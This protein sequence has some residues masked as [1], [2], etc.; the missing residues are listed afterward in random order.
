[1]FSRYRLLL[2]V[3]VVV[4]LAQSGAA[5][6]PPPGGVG[7]LMPALL[8]QN[9]GVQRELHLSPEQIQQLQPVIRNIRRKFEEEFG[10]IRNLDPAR[11]REKMQEIAAII[12]EALNKDLAGVFRPEQEQRFRQIIRQ[13]QGIFVFQDAEIV[14]RL[15][16]TVDQQGKVRQIADD[17]AAQIR[18]L[19]R[20]RGDDLPA[21]AATLRQA[22][23][24]KAAALLTEGQQKIWKE[25]LGAPVEVKPERLPAKAPGGN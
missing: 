16:L 20:T 7:P 19:F 3:G 10:Q 2:P 1:M 17:A 14:R 22:G 18:A 6:A 9:D 12:T 4:V 11:R 15:Q 8:L 5:Q 25:L 21:K 24:A 23:A 13:Q